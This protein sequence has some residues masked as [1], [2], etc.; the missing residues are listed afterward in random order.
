MALALVNNQGGTAVSGLTATYTVTA[1]GTASG[2]GLALVVG[3]RIVAAA[4]QTVTGIT[5]NK[6]NTWNQENVDNDATS[7][8][9]ADLWGVRPSVYI[10]GV[11]SITVTFSIAASSAWEFYELSGGLNGSWGDIGGSGHASSTAPT[12]STA[13]LAQSGEFV[14]AGIAWGSSTATIS[15]LT[16]GWTNETGLVMGTAPNLSLQPAHQAAPGTTALT[17]AGTLSAS[18]RWAAVACPFMAAAAAGGAVNGNHGNA[19]SNH[20]SNHGSNGR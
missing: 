14:V 13:T 19:H 16:A 4:S 10:S 6:G 1:T 18:N 8:V 11:T 7:T 12:V 17:Y 20:G 9:K 5:D 3:W 15:G 2:T